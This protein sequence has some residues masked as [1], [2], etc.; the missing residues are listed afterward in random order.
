MLLTLIFSVLKIQSHKFLPLIRKTKVVEI[1]GNK[2]MEEVKFMA[3]LKNLNWENCFFKADDSSSINR[4]IKNRF[5]VEV[6][7]PSASPPNRA[8][9]GETEGN[10]EEG[11]TPILNIQTL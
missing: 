1:K 10:H 11:P 7:H 3:E 5:E 2:K 8:V 9:A 6:N 4:V